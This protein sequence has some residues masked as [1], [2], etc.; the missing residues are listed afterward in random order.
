MA[1]TSCC[2]CSTY[3]WS[4][5]YFLVGCGFGSSNSLTSSC[6]FILFFSWL[7][8]SSQKHEHNII[9]QTYVQLCMIIN[10][11]SPYLYHIYCHMH[12]FVLIPGKTLNSILQPWM[13]AKQICEKN[14]FNFY[15]FV[16]GGE[17]F[18]LKNDQSF[19]I[20]NKKE[21]VYFPQI[22]QFY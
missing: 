10:N 13:N 20:K 15:F 17:Q 14:D 9:F 16:C 5:G 4:Y 7:Y 11:V 6:F 2:L 3:Q 8:V 22:Q 21:I 19:M 12:V 18:L 1:V